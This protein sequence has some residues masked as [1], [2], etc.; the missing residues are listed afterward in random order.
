MINNKIESLNKII[1]V[2]KTN[3]EKDPNHMA[4]YD[5]LLEKYIGLKEAVLNND[6][7]KT[8]ELLEWNK[9]FAPRI[10]YDGIG[11]KEI[12]LEVENLSKL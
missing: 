11:I 6:E 12:L 1:K 10:I 9:L 2:L 5:F 8:K 7:L 4:S 3:K